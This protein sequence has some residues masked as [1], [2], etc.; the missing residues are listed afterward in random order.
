M[1]TS[2]TK[3]RNNFTQVFL[4][5][6][7]NIVESEETKVDDILSFKIFMA[8]DYKI[9]IQYLEEVELVGD[10][11]RC[12]CCGEKRKDLLL[13]IHNDDLTKVRNLPFPI[14]AI[15]DIAS[16]YEAVFYPK[17]IAAY[18]HFLGNV[19][20]TDR[21]VIDSILRKSIELN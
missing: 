4:I 19:N 13:A 15:E 8:E 6:E 16:N 1:E 18:Q 20:S 9:R 10:K 21:K 12:E 7:F 3:L 17:R 11:F 14:F 5:P 2:N